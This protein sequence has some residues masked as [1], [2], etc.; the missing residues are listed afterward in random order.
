MSLHAHTLARLR[1]CYAAGLPPCRELV[2]LTLACLQDATDVQNLRVKRDELIRV[3]AMLVDDGT[4]WQRAAALESEAT[5][6]M[7]VWRTLATQ[8]PGPAFTVRACLHQ[9][10]LLAELPGSQRQYYRIIAAPKD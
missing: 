10:A 7:R 6:M 8:D 1:V 3:A 2:A 9:A 5:R 4:A